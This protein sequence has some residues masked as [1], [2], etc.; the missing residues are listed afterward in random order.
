MRRRRTR[1]GVTVAAHGRLIRMNRSQP[2]SQPDR[3]EA[4]TTRRTRR[5]PPRLP[6]RPG[7]AYDAHNLEEI[8]YLLLTCT[9]DLLVRIH[10]TQ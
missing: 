6:S 8:A 1:T 10:L 4:P 9:R 5:P 3:P 2:Q 7:P